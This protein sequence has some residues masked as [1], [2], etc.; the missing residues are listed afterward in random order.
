MASII[1]SSI[2]LLKHVH[3]TTTCCKPLLHATGVIVIAATLS[4]V[5]RA[6]CLSAVWGYVASDT[7]PQ[8]RQEMQNHVHC[9]HDLLPF[10]DNHA[11]TSLDK[12][13]VRIMQTRA[14][15]EMQVLQIVITVAQ[16]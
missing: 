1:T 2:L 4:F 7:L 11:S 12:G 6:E 14:C 13:G 8:Q 3:C 15:T 10:V 9:V 16:W 5:G